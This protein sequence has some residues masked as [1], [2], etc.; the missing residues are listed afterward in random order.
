MRRPIFV[1]TA[2]GWTDVSGGIMAL[3]HLCHLINMSGKASAFL[4]PVPEGEIV[5]FLCTEQINEVVNRQNMFLHSFKIN[6]SLD[7]PIFHGNI[8]DSNIVVVYGELVM[9]NPLCAQNVA[10]WVLYHM[11]GWRDLVSVS[12]G[13][14]LF[15]FEEEYLSVDI[16]GF[17]ETAE[18]ILNVLLPPDDALEFLRASVDIP[19]QNLVSD[20]VGTAFLVKKGRKIDTGLI[21]EDAICIDSFSRQRCLETFKNVRNFVSF[22]PHSFYSDIAAAYGCKSVVIA[23]TYAYSKGSTYRDLRPWLFFGDDNF[24]EFMPDRHALL[25]NWNQRQVKSQTSVDEFI[26]YWAARM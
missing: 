5:N 17:C 12:R 19:L 8:T 3:H 10:R 25:D 21:S 14:I 9:G 6:R 22:D 16:P 23:D 2:P 7:T 20:R 11:G 24:E 18:Q 1:V 13:E 26:D 4:F 15:R